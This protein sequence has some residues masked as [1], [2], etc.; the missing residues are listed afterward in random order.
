MPRY[1]L[2]ISYDGTRY[3]GW[4][5]QPNA[6]SVQQ[7]IQQALAIP[8]KENIIITGSGRTDA[9]VHA[10]AQYAHFDAPAPLDTHRLCRSLNGLL[11]RDIAIARIT[12][13]SEDFHARFDAVKRSYRYYFSHIPQALHRHTTT[14][15]AQ[16]LNIE[17]M[18]QAAEQL[19]GE[20][21]CRSFTPFD[22][23]LPHHRC[24]FFEAGFMPPDADGR[25]CFHISA[26]R[27][28]RSLVRSLMG[29]LVELGKGRITVKEFEQL[30]SKPERSAAGPTAPARG[31]VLHKVEYEGL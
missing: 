15:W 11:P 18:Q 27:F 22:P 25:Y 30:L 7:R 21:D 9:G 31:L 19:R 16:P 14:I 10:R 26:N 2:H 29:T 8:L 17:R 5:I 3:A 6:V 13:V 20:L 1:L 12:P 4:Q 23:K 24:I 28:L